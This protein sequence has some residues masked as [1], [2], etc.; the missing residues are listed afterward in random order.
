MLSH[1]RYNVRVPDTTS[2]I[3]SKLDKARAQLP[4][5]P[6][7]LKLVWAAARGWTAAWIVLLFIQGVLPVAIVTLTKVLVDSLVAAVDA[8]GAW[9]AVRG[10]L[11]LALLMAALLLLTELLAALTRFVRTAQGELV[12]DHISGLIHERAVAADLAH[13]ETPEYH[14][15][16]HRARVDSRHRAVALVE[17]LGSLLQNGITLIA[18][19]AVLFQF[20]WWVPVAL[21]AST[22]PAL[23]VAVRFAVE[24]HGWL[25]RITEENRR[26]CYYDWVMT[27]REAAPE[28]RLFDLGGPFAEIYQTIRARLR[29]ERLAI[30]R[31]EAAAEMTAGGIALV[32]MGAALAWMV[33]RTLRGAA[34]L[35]G[36]AMFFQAFS[37]G[38]KL[39]RSLLSTLGEA[40]SN[41]LF[42]ENLF[43]FLEVEPEITDPPSPTAAP[44]DEA[45]A[46]GFKDVTFRYPSADQPILERFTLAIPPGQVTAL[47]GVNGAGKSTLFKLLC[48]LYDP[49]SGAVEIGGLDIRRLPL[50]EL[51]RLVTVLFQD[52]VRYSETARRNIEL[53]DADVEH[54]DGEIHSSIE[55]AGARTLIDRLPDGLDSLL[56][57]W[58][59]GGTELSGGEWQRLSLARAVLR[60]AR[61]LLLDEPTSAM[62]SWA[63]TDWVNRF[64]DLARGRTAIIISHRLTTAM[65]ADVIHVM[66]SG[67]IVE[68]GS[69]R[70][71]LEQGGR[72]AEAWRAQMAGSVVLSSQF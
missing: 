25:M 30:A 15:R 9:D 31:K 13:Y 8:G 29:G 20:G 64:R 53:G 36:L 18:M 10:P 46:I 59:R 56:G 48:R 33:L 11:L 24:R 63:E 14:D 52:P 71:L 1:R 55:G 60:D 6:R 34:T 50:A 37:Q 5:L 19:A 65:K 62:D 54:N 35:G 47:L 38:Q 21:I 17:N 61:I 12:S 67:R 3:S 32:V 22:I 68:S 4:Y 40:V 57:S 16:M 49:T 51:R 45:L 66:D 69:H 7:A 27:H 58:F 42:M 23:V 28:I 72:Y 70:E 44:A 39:M 41:T 43:E 26:T 2:L